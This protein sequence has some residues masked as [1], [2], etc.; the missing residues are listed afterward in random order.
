MSAT[1]GLQDPKY[2]LANQTCLF[3]FR[4]HLIRE[5]YEEMFRSR[6]HLRD[7]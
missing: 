3:T 7:G 5:S 2:Q 4:F 6:S 1:S